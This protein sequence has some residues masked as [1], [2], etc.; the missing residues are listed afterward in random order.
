MLFVGGIV[1]FGIVWRITPE[2]AQSVLELR[3]YAATIATPPPAA[4]EEVKPAKSVAKK[5]AKTARAV[6]PVVAPETPVVA[7]VY[8]EFVPTPVLEKR[9]LAQPKLRPS[10]FKVAMEG[11]ELYSSNSPSG[12]IVRRLNRGDIVELQF[13]VNNAGPEWMYVNV[14]NPKGS[15]F[16][17]SEVV[18]KQETLEQASR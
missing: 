3:S 18:S 12:N 6:R 2:F 5:P 9:P 8:A 16:V 14:A 11:A 4:K 1:V 10:E 13:K 17:R 15:G 7:P